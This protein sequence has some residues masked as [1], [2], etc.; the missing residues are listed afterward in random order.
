[1]T[2]GANFTKS[3]IATPTYVVYRSRQGSAKFVASKTF[4]EKWLESR[5]KMHFKHHFYLYT[6]TQI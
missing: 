1:M 3:T 2:D 5:R 6:V 4:I